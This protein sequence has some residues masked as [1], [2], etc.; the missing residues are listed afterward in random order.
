MKL[1]DNQYIAATIYTK[2]KKVTYFDFL[3]RA[4]NTF[5]IKAIK[6]QIKQNK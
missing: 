5:V 3:S 2:K 4:F 1:I 6:D